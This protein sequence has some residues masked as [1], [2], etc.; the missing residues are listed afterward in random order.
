MSLMGG[1]ES[2]ILADATDLLE[3]GD[4]DLG[5]DSIGATLESDEAK[6]EEAAATAVT[7]SKKK[8]AIKRDSALPVIT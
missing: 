3:G 4:D 6:K 2:D 1:N 5:D 7:A 8:V